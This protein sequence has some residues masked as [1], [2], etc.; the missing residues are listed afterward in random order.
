MPRGYAGRL[1]SPG[2]ATRLW[3]E[4]NPEKARAAEKRR[5]RKYDSCYRRKWWSG[6]SQE[7]KTEKQA[8]GN[9]R[10]T[11]LRRWL[12]AYKLAAGC[13]DCG[14]KQHHAALHFDH[15]RGSKTINVCNAKSIAQAKS[16]ISK[17][18]V[19]CAN[20]HAAKTFRMY[21]CKPDIFEMTYEAVTE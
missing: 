3:R 2:E 14:Y 15:V 13:V 20:C 12:D 19:R 17:C 9:E 7:R 5:V 18:E 11:K 21:P 16:E 6:L 1:V 4:K 10:T 8:K